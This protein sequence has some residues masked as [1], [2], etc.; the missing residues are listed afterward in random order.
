MNEMKNAT[1]IT[2]NKTDQMEEGINDLECRNIEIIQSE[3]DR[4]ITFLKNE[5]TL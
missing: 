2:G 4:E 5:K 3:E 1:E